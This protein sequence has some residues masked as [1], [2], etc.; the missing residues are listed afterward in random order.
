MRSD[1]NEVMQIAVSTTVTENFGPCWGRTQREQEH[2]ARAILSVRV[3]VLQEVPGVMD[4]LRPGVDKII[5]SYDKGCVAIK[6]GNG[7]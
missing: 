2:T 5:F 7:T 3:N 6:H 4:E 1:S